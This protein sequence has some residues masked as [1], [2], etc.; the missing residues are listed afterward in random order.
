MYD[1]DIYLS[2]SFLA[3]LQNRYK[4]LKIRQFIISKHH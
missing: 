1:V 4:K 2:Q 3:D